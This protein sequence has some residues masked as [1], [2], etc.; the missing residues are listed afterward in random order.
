MYHPAKKE[1]RIQ[2]LGDERLISKGKRVTV[3]AGQSAAVGGFKGRE[4]KC[5]SLP[6]PKLI[7]TSIVF[8]TVSHQAP[9][10]DES[11]SLQ[12]QRAKAARARGRHR[13]HAQRRNRKRTWPSGTTER[14]HRRGEGSWGRKVGRGKEQRSV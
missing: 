1:T 3:V 11:Q 14:T 12:V 7:A 10:R 2:K 6:L 13:L 8:T 9:V 5:F 4:T